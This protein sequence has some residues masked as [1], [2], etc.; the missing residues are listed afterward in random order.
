[1]V[2][3]EPCSITTI[4]GSCAAVCLFDPRTRTGGMNHFL[5]PR[6]GARQFEPARYGDV[7]VELLLRQVLAAGANAGALQA[8]LFGGAHV[9]STE[10]AKAEDLGTQNTDAARAEL[11]RLKVPVVAHDVGGRRGRKLVFSTDDGRA[12]VKLL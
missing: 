5:L 2:S 9:L 3:R 12:W 1:M 8:K 4:L 10:P 6:G 7:A 11:A